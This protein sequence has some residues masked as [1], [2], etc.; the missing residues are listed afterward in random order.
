MQFK[1]ILPLSLCAVF[2]CTA[3]GHAALNDVAVFAPGVENWMTVQQQ[4]ELA[5]YLK[6]PGLHPVPQ[7]SLQSETIRGYLATNRMISQHLAAGPRFTIMPT[8][9]I[10]SPG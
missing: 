7:N 2:Y 4:K 8:R 6:A 5:T 1:K 3:P 9:K 10:S